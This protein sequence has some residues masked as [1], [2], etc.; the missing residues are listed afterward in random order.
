MKRRAERQRI[1]DALPSRTMKLLL[2]VDATERS[3]WGISYAIWRKQTGHDVAVSLLFVAEPVTSW[4]V[5]R[6]LTQ[7]EVRR[8][9]VERGNNLLDDAAKPL[10]GAGVPVQSH[11]REGDIAFQILDTA[12]QL[13][14][15]EIVL[16][17]PRPRWAGLFSLDIVR[18]VICRQSVVPVITVNPDGMPEGG[19]QH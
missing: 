7:E 12:E 16:P 14:C 1:V 8:F 9:Q 4:Q 10:E 18:E 15:D 5:L 6:F 19:W 2:P 3:R 17:I 13:D 11:Y